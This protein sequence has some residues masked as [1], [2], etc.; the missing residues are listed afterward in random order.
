MMIALRLMDTK[1]ISE[2]YWC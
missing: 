1:N 2:N